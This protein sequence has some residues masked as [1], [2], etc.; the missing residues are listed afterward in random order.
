M[1]VVRTVSTP[2][3][4]TMKS[5]TTIIADPIVSALIRTATLRSLWK[6]RQTR[7][8]ASLCAWTALGYPKHMKRFLA[9]RIR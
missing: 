1:L 8:D 9:E 6:E 3:I 7:L 5:K 2:S 4:P